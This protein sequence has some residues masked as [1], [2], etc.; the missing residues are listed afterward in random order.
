MT[1]QITC[2]NSKCKIHI[3]FLHNGILHVV[4]IIMVKHTFSYNNVEDEHAYV[5]L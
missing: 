4:S 5:G 1:Q 3:V 2:A